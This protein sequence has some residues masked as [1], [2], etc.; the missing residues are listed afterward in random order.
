MGTG[1]WQVLV[2]KTS[3]TSP[4]PTKKLSFKST[5]QFVEM[6]TALVEKSIYLPPILVGALFLY[7][8]MFGGVMTEHPITKPYTLLASIIQ[9]ASDNLLHSLMQFVNAT[10]GKVMIVKESSFSALQGLVNT[11]NLVLVNIH[12]MMTMITRTVNLVVTTITKNLY[13]IVT[14]VTETLSTIRFYFKTVAHQTYNSSSNMFTALKEKTTGIE[15]MV[16]SIRAFFFPPQK[17]TL[18]YIYLGA[19]ITVAF[20]VVAATVYYLSKGRTKT[21]ELPVVADEPVK[22][23]QE[24]VRKNP[25]RRKTKV[26]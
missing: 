2:R 14:T 24:A 1:I 11:M 5:M 20:L 7:R 21:V 26:N 18:E 6:E 25:V 4:S 16:A 17:N 13:S 10:H 9:I 12:R 3:T 19:L 22:P 15:M 8:T 23:Q